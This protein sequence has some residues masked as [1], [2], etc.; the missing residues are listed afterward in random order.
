MTASELGAGLDDEVAG[1]GGEVLLDGGNQGGLGGMR[2]S[3][4]VCLKVAP[5]K[6]IHW[7]EVGAARRPLLLGDD[8]VAVLFQPGQGPVGDMAGG[9]VLLPHPGAVSNNSS[10]PGEH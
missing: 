10:D 7:I 3:V 9:R 8:I 6:I 4:S 2:A 1:H 5:D